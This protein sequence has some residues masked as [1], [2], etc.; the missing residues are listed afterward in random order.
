M[1]ARFYAIALAG[2]SLTAASCGRTVDLATA[3]QVEQV[4]TGWFDAGVV[5]GQNKLVPSISF[6]LRNTSSEELRIQLNA[7]YKILPEGE[8]RDDAFLQNIRVPANGT[9]EPMTI[10]AENG[11]T[12][13]AP[14]ADMLQHRLFQDFEVRLFAKHGSSSWVPLGEY[15]VERQLLTR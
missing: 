7:V 1:L 10:R 8:D 3:L 13:E 6:T 11:F 9:A 4:T 15:R 14:R 12:S 5:N 2:L